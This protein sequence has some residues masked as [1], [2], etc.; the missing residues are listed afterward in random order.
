MTHRHELFG[1]V[2][3]HLL[4]IHSVRLIGGRLV[5]IAHSS[6]SYAIANGNQSGGRPDAGYCVV[7][8]PA[9]CSGTIAA[10]PGGGMDAR[11][12][13]G[14]VFLATVLSFSSSRS[15]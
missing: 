13:S 2:A 5:A 9:R 1:L 7:A 3:G 15:V 11:R 14:D 6:D 8:F 12:F 10:Q 4:R